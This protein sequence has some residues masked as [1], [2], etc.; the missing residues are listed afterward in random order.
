MSKKSAKIQTARMNDEELFRALTEAYNETSGG[1]GGGGEVLTPYDTQVVIDNSSYT[2]PVG[3]RATI[4]MTRR[5]NQSSAYFYINGSI[6]YLAPSTNAYWPRMSS[7]SG[8][9]VEGGTVLQV[10]GVMLV[11]MRLI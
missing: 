9:E 3:Y 10:Y 11:Q 2:V 7:V 1:G 4:F 5:Y 8:V 6:F